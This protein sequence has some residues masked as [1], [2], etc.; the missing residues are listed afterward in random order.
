SSPS[1]LKCL[2][3]VPAS[4]P[5]RLCW[6]PQVGIYVACGGD[7][8]V[9]QCDDGR[10]VSSSWR[11]DGIADC[12]DGSDDA[13]LFPQ[14]VGQ[15]RCSVLAP[16]TASHTGS[17]AIGTRTV[18]TAGMRRG[19]PSSHVCLGSGSAGTGC[20]SWLSG[21]AMGSMTVAIPQMKMSVV[22]NMHA[23]QWGETHLDHV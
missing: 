12:M 10:C 19:V 11:C 4:L 2:W 6:D 7:P 3:L 22:S 5:V 8:H 13:A 18:R 9:W 1:V 15:R 16:T 20:A 14:C 17:Y 23:P 21:S